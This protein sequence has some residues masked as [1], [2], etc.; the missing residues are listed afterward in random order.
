MGN[1]FDK[2]L[3]QLAR[4]LSSCTFLTSGGRSISYRSSYIERDALKRKEWTKL[5]RERMAN[6][7]RSEMAKLDRGESSFDCR[8][9]IV[10]CV[11]QKWGRER[12]QVEEAIR[13]TAS[14][15]AAE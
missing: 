9:E 3:H 10:Y 11:G 8:N 6:D 7:V 2:G 5:L 4:E 13:L 15:S 1:G 12:T 14:S